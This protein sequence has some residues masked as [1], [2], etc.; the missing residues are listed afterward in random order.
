MP[1]CRHYKKEKKKRGG[2]KGNTGSEFTKWLSMLLTQ[3][4]SSMRAYGKEGSR[5]CGLLCDP[6]SH[7][8]KLISWIFLKLEAKFH[9]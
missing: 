4:L 7:S 9:L 5:G 2:T 6:V 3:H 1:K 8:L